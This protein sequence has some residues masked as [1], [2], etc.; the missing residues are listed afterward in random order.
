MKDVNELMQMVF[1]GLSPLVI[2]D[3]ADEGERIVV[4]ARTLLD[5]AVCPL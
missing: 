4:R 5:T 2:E 3:V 1:S